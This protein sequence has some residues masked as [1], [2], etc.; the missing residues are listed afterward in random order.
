MAILI[1]IQLC[2]S[3]IVGVYFLSR[4]KKESGETPAAPQRTGGSS[5]GEMDKLTRMRAIRLS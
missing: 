5:R 3:L 2:V 4:M 1:C